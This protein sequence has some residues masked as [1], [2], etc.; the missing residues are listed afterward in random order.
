MASRRSVRWLWL[1]GA[2]VATRMAGAQ[3]DVD[4]ARARA[5][6]GEAVEDQRR[7]DDAVA[8]EK[9]R[10]VALVRDT[11][12][13]E[14][15]VASCLERLGRRRPAFLAYARSAK[16]GVGDA[17]SVD[18]VA[19]ANDRIAKLAESMGKLVLAVRAAT[20]APVD[21]RIDDEPIAEDELRA[22]VLLD[23]GSHRIDVREAGAKPAHALVALGPAGRADLSIVLEPDVASARPVEATPADS[24]TRR[25]VGI[26]SLAVGG[27]ALVTGGILLLVRHN[28]V[29]TIHS[30]CPAN[31]CP[32][33]RRDEI[34]GLRSTAS[35]LGPAGAILGVAGAAAIVGGGV[36][37]AL[38]P[39]K[40]SSH[41]W[42]APG[43]SG[44]A[45]LSFGVSF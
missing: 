44:V 39:E 18:V 45:G 33:S 8:L 22:P 28:D 30:D 32:V 41:A 20:T 2:M 14:F 26:V 40:A 27:A 19:E 38:G 34:E 5:L 13:V 15:R 7:G 9:F 3:S 25:D 42:L 36:L 1:V 12:Q 10:R 35:A 4:L 23:A 29:A 11:A 17:Q 43:S 6:F 37:F 31:V 16:L 24:T 21:V